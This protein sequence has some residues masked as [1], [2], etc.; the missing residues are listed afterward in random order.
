[1][2]HKGNQHQNWVTIS[3]G[4]ELINFLFHSLRYLFL[5]WVGKVL[6]KVWRIR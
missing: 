4:S 1:M 5:L 2:R 6:G 3:T